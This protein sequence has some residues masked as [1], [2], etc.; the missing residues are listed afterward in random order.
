M[1][2][3]TANDINRITRFIEILCVINKFEFETDIGKEFGDN[4]KTGIEDV[5]KPF[6]RDKI[7]ELRK[8]K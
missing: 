5:I 3:P 6:G 7:I 2:Y 4:I 8:I 1:D